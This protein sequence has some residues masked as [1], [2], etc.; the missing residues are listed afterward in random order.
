MSVKALGIALKL[1]FQGQ[2]QLIYPQTSV[3]AMVVITCVLT[4]MNYLNKVSLPS[5][6]CFF[7]QPLRHIKRVCSVQSHGAF[8]N[9]ALIPSLHSIARFFTHSQSASSSFFLSHC[10]GMF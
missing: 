9:S 10:I 8:A 3:F 1:T 5:F 7:V 2:N 6:L 4:Q